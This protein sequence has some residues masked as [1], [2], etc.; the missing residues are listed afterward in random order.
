MPIK[1]PNLDDRTFADLVK[2]AH[3]LIPVYAPEWTDHNESDPGITFIELFAYL[4]EMLIYRLNRVTDANVCA[5]LKLIDGI[6]RIPSTLNRGKVCRVEGDENALSDEVQRVVLQLHSQNRAVSCEDFQRLVLAADEQLKVKEFALDD[7]VRRVVLHLRSQ[8]RAVTCTDFERLALD[9]DERVK[10]ARCVPQRDLTSKTPYEQADAHVSV[11]IYPSEVADGNGATVKLTQK[12]WDH[13]EPRRLLATRLHVVGPKLVK[14]GVQVRIFLKP[15]AVKEN[16][17]QEVK[18]KLERFFAPLRDE[19]EREGW[20]FGRSVY[21]SD[22]YA[23]LDEIPGVD[24]VTKPKDGG[25]LTAPEAARRILQDGELVAIRLNSDELVDLRPE[26]SQ[27][28]FVSPLRK[29]FDKDD[30]R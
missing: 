11:V 21:V 15:D 25:I 19:H 26:Q 28:E 27:I 30:G 16:V 5:F 1:L 2:E 7:E 13:L 29:D 3:A 14:L 8:D 22:I 17:E 20:P 12:V 9:A 18:D 10:R 4:T 23:L 24:F 6:E